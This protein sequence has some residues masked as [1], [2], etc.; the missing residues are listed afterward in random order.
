MEGELKGWG[1]CFADKPKVSFEF[2]SILDISILSISNGM[3]FE[4][5]CGTASDVPVQI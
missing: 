5:R 1:N 4:C 2:V 3:L